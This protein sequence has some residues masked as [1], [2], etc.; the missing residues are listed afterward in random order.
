M[1]HQTLAEMID[2]QVL[3]T[4]DPHDTIRSACIKMA[5]ANIGALPVVE[6]DGTLVGMLSERDVIKRSVIVYR[7]SETTIVGQAM[8]PNPQWLPPDATPIEAYRT[9]IG[10]EFRHLPVCEGG[11]LRGIVSIRDFSPQAETI[12]EKLR[13]SA[14]KAAKKRT[15]FLP[16]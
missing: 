2:G 7:P 8:T 16:N 11:R 6:A 4:T 12:L 10:G 14:S 3:Q 1:D 5:S 13:R 15:Q 9:M